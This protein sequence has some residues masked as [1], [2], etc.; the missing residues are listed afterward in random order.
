M[1]ANDGAPRDL[2]FTPEPVTRDVARLVRERHPQI[3]TTTGLP[4]LATAGAR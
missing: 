4:L 3:G 1:T 2:Q